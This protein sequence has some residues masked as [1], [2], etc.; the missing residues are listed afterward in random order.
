MNVLSVNICGV[1][2]CVKRRR[3]S[4]LCSEHRISF[5]AIQESRVASVDLFELKSL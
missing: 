1:R 5:L 4:K 3:I 2:E